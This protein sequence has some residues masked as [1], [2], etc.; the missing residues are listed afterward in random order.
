MYVCYTFLAYDI[1]FFSIEI[2]YISCVPFVTFYLIKPV[3]QVDI[4]SY[5]LWVI[6]SRSKVAIDSFT[7]I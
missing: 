2:G 6:I 7:C 5:E 1:L 3:K 4:V